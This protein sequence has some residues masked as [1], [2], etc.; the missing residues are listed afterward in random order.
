MGRGGGVRSDGGGSSPGLVI[1][2]VRSGSRF[3]WWAV[4]FVCGWLSTFVGG[5]P[6]SCSWAGRPRLVRGRV[7]L[8]LFVGARGRS[9]RWSYLFVDVGGSSWSLVGA[10]GRWWAL[11]VVGGRSQSLVVV[12][13]CSSSSVVHHPHLHPSSSSF[14]GQSLW[15]ARRNKDDQRRPLSSFVVRLPRRS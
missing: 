14:L 10:R 13:G 2:C 4:T 11:V 5:S 7:A 1:A 15:S 12:R 6:S 8:I 3:R 9:R